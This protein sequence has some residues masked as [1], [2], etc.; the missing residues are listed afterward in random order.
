MGT[1]KPF[2]LASAR[3]L[4]NGQIDPDF[5][6]LVRY[7]DQE[8]NSVGKST[9]FEMEHIRFSQMPYLFFPK[10]M[11]SRITE[12]N[13]L[14]W[15]HV[16]F[17]GLTGPNGP[18]PLEITNSLYQRAHN[19]YDFSPSRFLD[20]INHRFIALFYRAWKYNEQTVQADHSKDDLIKT[21]IN[22]LAGSRPSVPDGIPTEIENYNADLFGFQIKSAAG[23]ETLLQRYFHRSIRVEQHQ[24]SK[25]MLE[26][27]Y[28]CV[29]GKNC[30]ELGVSI[31]LGHSCWSRTSKFLIRTDV[32][33]YSDSLDLMPGSRGYKMLV[34]LVS[35]YL[36]RPQE[37]DLEL[38]LKKETLP[39]P[40]LDGS[41]QLGRG[42]WLS[43]DRTG[44]YP[45]K[46][47]A[48]RLLKR[49]LQN[50]IQQQ[51]NTAKGEK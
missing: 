10:T 27:R 25:V 43:G 19:D 23:L 44:V 9:L 8:D 50:N 17:M 20:I 48:Y 39:D 21:V 47:G 12:K 51:N 32:L 2:V 6:E 28:R 7:L 36:D 13:G 41:L 46:I 35:H 15:I 11:V 42:L 38:N 45:L 33:S 29:P 24:L 3:G 22:S 5:F 16:Y 37:Y 26:K 4:R 49:N 18:L 30:A 1:L 40:H 31:Q 14:S 34:Q